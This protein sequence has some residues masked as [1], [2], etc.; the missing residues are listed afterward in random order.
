MQV[1]FKLYVFLSLCKSPRSFPQLHIV[2]PYLFQ[3]AWER[4]APAQFP[5]QISSSPLF[6]WPQVTASWHYSHH[7]G[8]LSHTLPHSL[9]VVHT[10]HLILLCDLCCSGFM[11]LPCSSLICECCVLSTNTNCAPWEL[12][13]KSKHSERWFDLHLTLWGSSSGIFNVHTCPT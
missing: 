2:C 6:K 11:C 13:V 4:R 12:P 5:I 7:L 9:L 10:A 3:V 8:P 1:Y